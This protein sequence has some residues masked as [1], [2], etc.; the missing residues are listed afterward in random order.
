[1]QSMSSFVAQN[2]GARKEKRALK[3]MWTGIAIGA[4]IGVFI[5]IFTLFKGDMMASI[6]TNDEA[7]I[8]QA[9]NY[10]KGFAL[11]AIVTS[12]LFS[13]MGYF[14]GHGKTMFVMA[15]GLVQ[16]FLIRLPMAYIMSIQ[17][18]ANLTM[19]GLSAPTAT[20]FGIIF[21]TIYFIKTKKEFLSNEK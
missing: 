13:Y 8:M 14:N 12:F 15:Q 7:V 18:N 3:A 6:F 1:M 2:V 10:L 11:E 17:P 16:S 19:I 4:S 5:S 21:C 20:I 9:N